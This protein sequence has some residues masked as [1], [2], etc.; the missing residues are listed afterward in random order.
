MSNPFRERNNPPFDPRVFNIEL[1]RIYQSIPNGAVGEVRND[2]LEALGTIRTH[3]VHITP[4]MRHR[5]ITTF[6]D[7]L[8]R[9]H[10]SAQLPP[11]GNGISGGTR[12]GRLRAHIQQCIRDIA[13]NNRE[14]ALI[15]ERIYA[16]RIARGRQ[17]HELMAVAQYNL[18]LEHLEEEKN[19]LEDRNRIIN[20]V[21]QGLEDQMRALRQDPNVSSSDSSSSNSEND[22]GDDSD[23]MEALDIG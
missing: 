9:N 15:N 6:N 5:Y 17:I 22:S 3:S 19:D 18:Q 10:L 14:I 8:V 23:D 1:E 12:I 7:Y 11:R 20:S 16:I 4:F 13:Q 2:I 21:K